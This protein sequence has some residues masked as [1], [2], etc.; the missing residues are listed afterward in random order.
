M[1]L[2]QYRE[3]RE[4]GLRWLGSVPTHWKI[5]PLKRMLDIQNGE[6]H[7]SVEQA[8]GVPVFGSGGPF[9]FASRS[10]YEGESVLLGRKGTI[11]KPQYV[12]GHFWVVDT[13]YWSKII[14]GNDGKFA[15]YSALTIPFDYYSTSTALPSMTKSVL[16][17]HLVAYPPLAE[18][19]IIAKFLDDETEKI[20]TLIAEQE[21]LIALLQERR[22]ALIAAAVT[23]QIDVRGAVP[24]LGIHEDLT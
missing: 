2:P 1:K 19:I 11:D 13:T 8:E 20:D 3:Y 6:D 5:G 7:K 4:S 23:G 22:R 18:Q 14:P 9:A 17:A 24:R 15:Y 10:L 12:T 21:K 16:G